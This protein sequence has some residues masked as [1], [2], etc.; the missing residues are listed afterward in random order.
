MGRVPHNGFFL[1]Y[2]TAVHNVTALRGTGFLA[3]LPEARRE[4]AELIRLTFYEQN[5]YLQQLYMLFPGFVPS[6]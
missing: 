6:S 4:K 5:E 1:I 3:A 2:L